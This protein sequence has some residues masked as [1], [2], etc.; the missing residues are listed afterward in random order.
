MKHCCLA[1]KIMLRSVAGGQTLTPFGLLA[2]DLDLLY[3]DVFYVQIE[4]HFNLWYIVSLLTFAHFGEG[5][6]WGK[7]KAQVFNYHYQNALRILFLIQP[8]GAHFK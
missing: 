2:L 3:R 5:R 6:G 1:N 4:R 7:G 8:Q